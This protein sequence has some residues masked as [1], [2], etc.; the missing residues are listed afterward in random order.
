MAFVLDKR[1]VMISPVKYTEVS[2]SVCSAF[3][4]QEQM[5]HVSLRV[6]EKKSG[7]YR[8]FS[9]QH[10]FCNGILSKWRQV[11]SVNQYKVSSVEY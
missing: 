9:I 10:S 7:A 3:Q 6:Q 5:C 1:V 2:I 11:P 4:E 8:L